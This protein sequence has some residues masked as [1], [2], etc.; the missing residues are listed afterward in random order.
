MEGLKV[1]QFQQM[2]LAQLKLT[3]R[4][5][6]AWFWG[7]FFPVILMSIFMVIF[8][9]GSNKNFNQ[10]LRLSSQTKMKLLT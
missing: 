9:G 2:F 10:A 3:L 8:A 7:N 1:K 4:E 6:Q 5:K